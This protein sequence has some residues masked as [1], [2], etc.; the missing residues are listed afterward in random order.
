MEATIAAAY[1]TEIGSDPPRAALARASIDRQARYA[2]PGSA[3]ARHW[4][5]SNAGRSAKEL[6]DAS[7]LVN[8]STILTQNPRYISTGRRPPRRIAGATPLNQRPNTTD[9]NGQTTKIGEPDCHYYGDRSTVEWD[10]AAS[11]G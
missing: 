6:I 4:P 5:E 1:S 7:T 2:A 8:L 3:F 11:A 10:R 9:Q